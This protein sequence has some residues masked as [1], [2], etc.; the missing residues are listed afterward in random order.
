M[1][2]RSGRHF[3][4]IPG[5]SPVPE[6]I[7]RAMDMPIIDHRG[8]DFAAL[9]ARVLEKLKGVFKTEQ[10]VIIYP[11][12]GT[13]AWEAALVNV[14]SPGDKILMYET[15]QFATLWCELATRIGLEP[16][17]IP[18]DWRHGIDP[19]AIASRLQ[20][21]GD[22]QLKAVCCVHNETST[23]ILSDIA[24]VRKAI[25]A[26]GHPALLVVDTISG[27]GCAE[28]RHD[29]WQVDVTIS[30]SQ[31]GLMLPPGAGFNCLSRKALDAHE[32]SGL[33]KS[34]WDWGPMLGNN[35]NG[36][37]PYTPAT[38][39][40]YGLDE[41]LKLL[42][43]EEGLE[44]VFARHQRHAMATRTAVGHWGLEV[45]CQVEEQHSPVLTAVVLPDGHDADHVRETILNKFD[46]SLGTGLGK[47]KGKV[48][49][50]G[51][52]GDI[53]DLTLVA[54]LGGVEMGLQLAGVPIQAGG[55]QRA[56]DYLRATAS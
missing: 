56:M 53:N 19:Q 37:F 3:L 30:C 41:A 35:A 15:G 21:D 28:Y 22:Q 9:G 20:A 32:H 51:H 49:R 45:L 40:L 54:T 36:Y 47:V 7:L 13:G 43:E 42:L 23:G 24:A 1:A 12:S 50:I 11:T 10:P 6:R 2:Y 25:D 18:G 52:L 39:L 34:Y 33:K 38:A 55:C 44:H 14:L 27:L 29:E 31:K 5:P 48:F 16:V 8:P 26:T 17:L 4:Q 46:M